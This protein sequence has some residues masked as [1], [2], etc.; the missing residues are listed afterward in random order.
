MDKTEKLN[1]LKE[2]SATEADWNR[3]K[4][5]KC[6]SLSRQLLKSIREYQKW[7]SKSDIFAKFL[8]KWCVLKHRFW[9]VVTG[10]DIPLN[11]QIGGG[12][13]LPHPNGVVIHP[14]AK[15]G[16]NKFITR[17]GNQPV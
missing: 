14:S 11:C 15:I 17:K 7:G 4:L 5:T 8:I 2:I 6:W 13:I 1:T 3:E 9:G 16:V 10:A 12:L